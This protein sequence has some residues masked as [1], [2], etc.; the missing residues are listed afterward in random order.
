MHDSRGLK[1]RSPVRLALN[2]AAVHTRRPLPV[3]GAGVQLE[4]KWASGTNKNSYHISQPPVPSVCCHFR[5]CQTN[6]DKRASLQCRG[7][8]E[9]VKRLPIQFPG[10]WPGEQKGLKNRGNKI[11]LELFLLAQALFC[12]DAS[13]R[14][15][16]GLLLGVAAL[17]TSQLHAHA[18]SCP[19]CEQEPVAAKI[20]KTGQMNKRSKNNEQQKK[21]TNPTVMAAIW[22]MALER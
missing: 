17:H 5:C 19:L 9:G 8:G 1:L 4:C 14:T 13:I 2:P 3:H 10:R 15:G 18:L 11:I 7:K 21:A 12:V 16:N 20:N 6:D 22:T